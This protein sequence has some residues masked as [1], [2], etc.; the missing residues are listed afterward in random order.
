[1]GGDGDEWG[2]RG[3]G[4]VVYMSSDRGSSGDDVGESSPP[5]CL[6]GRGPC[7]FRRLRLGSVVAAVLTNAATPP[8][9]RRVPG[10]PPCPRR[11]A[12]LLLLL[13]RVPLPLPL[14]L[15]LPP[16]PMARE[17][18]RCHS[19]EPR[20]GTAHAAASAFGMSHP[21]NVPLAGSAEFDV[22]VQQE[23]HM[24]RQARRQQLS[25]VCRL[26]HVPT[27]MRRSVLF[28]H[29]HARPGTLLLCH[30]PK[31]P[32]ALRLLALCFPSPV[33]AGKVPRT[34]CPAARS[35][36]CQSPRQSTYNCTVGSVPDDQHHNT[37]TKF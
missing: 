1:M 34:A 7:S 26:P 25:R 36:R 16:A 12:L 33:P 18:A 17:R 31:L 2:S 30:G 20:G 15:P 24:H 23:R 5:R 28:R 32:A 10:R 29:V 27:Q 21:R 37:G 14:P 6:P 8:P 11:R 4:D 3:E 19:S 9:R 22:F 35:A 13:L